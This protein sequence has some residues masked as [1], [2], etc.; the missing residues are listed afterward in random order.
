MKSVM[1][2]P[3]QKKNPVYRRMFRNSFRTFMLLH[4]ALWVYCLVT[5]WV[6]YAEWI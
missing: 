5:T 1:K 3:S 6:N 4:V 2:K